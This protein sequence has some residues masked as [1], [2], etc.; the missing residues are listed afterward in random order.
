M[1]KIYLIIGVSIAVFGLWVILDQNCMKCIVPFNAEK[2]WICPG[3]CKPEPRLF[4]W[5][6][7]I[8][9]RFECDDF[10]C[11]DKEFY[12]DTEWKADYCMQG[13]ILDKNKGCVK[14]D[15]P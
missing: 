5:V 4:S 11:I 9:P 13:Y 1:R 7:E 3:V 15:S 2:N 12:L 10:M 6:K 14:V 8:N